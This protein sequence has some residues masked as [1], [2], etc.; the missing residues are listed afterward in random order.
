MSAPPKDHLDELRAQPDCINPVA[1]IWKP[2][3]FELLLLRCFHN[4]AGPPSF[5]WIDQRIFR[6]PER[7]SRHGLY[8][9]CAFRPE[10]MS[11]LIAKL[12]RP[13][14]TGEAGSR[15][16]PNWPGVD[17]RS[18]NRLWPNDLQTTEWFAETTFATEEMAQLF[19][20]HW[21]DR[22]SGKIHD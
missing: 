7:L 20:N 11:W 21:A 12:G 3:G 15:R 1:A 18:A 4:G 22:L 13:A 19:R 2:K 14:A 8:F 5:A 6:T 9:G 10:V 17:W 16:N